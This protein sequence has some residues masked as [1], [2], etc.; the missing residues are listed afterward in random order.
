MTTNQIN[1]FANQETK[2]SNLANEKLK[3]YDIDKR[4]KLGY[5]NLAETNRSNVA[6]EIETN[7]HNLAT[8]GYTAQELGIK[9]QDA[10]TRQQQLSINWANLAEQSRANRAN[11]SLALQRLNED[12]RA[13]TAKET[14]NAYTALISSKQQQTAETQAQTQQYK[15]ETER[16]QLNET[17]RANL[18]KEN[19][20]NRHNLAV[21]QETKRANVINQSIGLGNLMVNQ[22]KATSDAFNGAASNYSNLFN[23]MM[24]NRGVVLPGDFTTTQVIWPY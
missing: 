8:E 4:T 10:D 17:N 23:S 3:K 20:T 7:R 14:T 9:Q 1:Y 22:Q 18:V 13:N 6:R 19:E 12:Y 11:E 21:E 16:M 5:D 2:R 24:R 15:A